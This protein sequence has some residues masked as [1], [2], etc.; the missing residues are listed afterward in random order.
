MRYNFISQVY[1]YDIECM[2]SDLDF[3]FL[4]FDFIIL[5][6]TSLDAHLSIKFLYFSGSFLLFI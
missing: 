5:V 2:F 6:F 1:L 4:A 3:L